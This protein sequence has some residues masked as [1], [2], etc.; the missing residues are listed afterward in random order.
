MQKGNQNVYLLKAMFHKNVLWSIGETFIV[1][2]ILA[3]FLFLSIFYLFHIQVAAKDQNFVEYLMKLIFLFFSWHVILAYVPFFIFL[4][5]ACSSTKF[6]TPLAELYGRT[7]SGVDSVTKIKEK[8]II[9]LYLFS[10][11]TLIFFLYDTYFKTAPYLL[12]AGL[13]PFYI[14]QYKSWIR[15]LYLAVGEDF[16]AHYAQ[17]RQQYIKRAAILMLLMH[18]P[19][20]WLFQPWALQI[21][22]HIYFK[23]TAAGQ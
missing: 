10:A 12:A 20:F 5:A 19:I 16:Y 21:L 1:I 13:I 23:E 14:L 22:A 4:K 18:I 3:V 8:L 6:L 15:G 7:L 9:G 17:H 11:V 2:G